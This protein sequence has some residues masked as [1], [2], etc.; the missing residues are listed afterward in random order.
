MRTPR[1]DTAGRRRLAHKPGKGEGKTFYRGAPLGKGTAPVFPAPRGVPTGSGRTE[2][3]R[4]S[5]VK[6][7]ISTHRRDRPGGDR[8]SVRRTAPPTRARRPAAQEG[9]QLR[10]RRAPASAPR[11]PVAR[12]RPAPAPAPTR[13]SAAR[14]WPARPSQNFVAEEQLPGAARAEKI[15]TRLATVQRGGET[16]TISTS[17]VA[18]V[19]LAESG[20]GRLADHR[21]Q[22]GR[23]GAARQGRLRRRRPRPP[24]GG[25][26]FNPTGR[27]PQDLPAPRP[28]ASRSTVPGVAHIAIGTGTEQASGPRRQGDRRRRRD[29]PDPD[30]QP[31]PDRPHARPSSSAA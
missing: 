9:H 28:R 29:P 3:R 27:R 16:A 18:R 12:S 25:I 5:C 8:G 22:L 26:T 2:T 10:L 21:D 15:T 30:R 20:L 7:T 19:V 11:S 24:I 23:E 1:P 4:G 17:H 14:T 6:K 31:G 13:R